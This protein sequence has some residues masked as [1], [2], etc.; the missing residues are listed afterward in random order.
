MLASQAFS[1]A[2][3]TEPM[4]THAG[5]SAPFKAEATGPGTWLL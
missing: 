3:V 1:G 5:H 4:V 2:G